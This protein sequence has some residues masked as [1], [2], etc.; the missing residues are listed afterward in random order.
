MSNLQINITH[1]V[2]KIQTWRCFF[3]ALA[4]AKKEKNCN[5]SILCKGCITI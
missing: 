4:A 1:P 3:N 5:L 2:L